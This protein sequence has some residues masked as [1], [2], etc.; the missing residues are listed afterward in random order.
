MQGLHELCS[1]SLVLLPCIRL[2]LKQDLNRSIS[3]TLIPFGRHDRGAEEAMHASDQTGLLRAN[4]SY[5]ARSRQK[6][7]REV[8]LR[9]RD[10][11]QMPYEAWVDL[12]SRMCVFSSAWQC[13]PVCM[14]VPMC[15]WTTDARSRWWVK[16]REEMK[17]TRVG[18]VQQIYL[19]SPWGDPSRHACIQM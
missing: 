12:W 13:F 14:T 18:S 11:R 16:A 2:H 4:A 5:W 15:L 10:L 17:T 9:C 8:A 6:Q 7:W 19:P 1:L 3:L